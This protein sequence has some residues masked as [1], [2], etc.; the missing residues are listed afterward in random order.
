MGQLRKKWQEDRLTPNHISNCFLFVCLFGYTD[1]IWKFL[2]QGLSHSNNLSHGSDNTE[3][4]TARLPRNSILNVN[5]VGVPQWL[6]GL[7][8]QHC[9][10]YG[11]GLI[12]GLGTSACHG[13]GQKV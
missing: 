4:L 5:D 6:S 3:S 10:C 8:T 12:P 11:L 7:R 13:C 9:H 2:G 1:G